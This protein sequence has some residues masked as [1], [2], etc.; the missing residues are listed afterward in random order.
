MQTYSP[1]S[2]ILEFKRASYFHCQSSASV[3]YKKSIP[4]NISQCLGTSTFHHSF[5]SSKTQDKETS[6]MD[7]GNNDR[8][9]LHKAW[10]I[11]SFTTTETADLVSDSIDLVRFAGLNA[12][13]T[14]ENALKCEWT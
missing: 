6:S 1:Y 7:D 11:K 4:C 8:A 10:G 14:K 5:S 3:S 9:V 13:N 12:E 2:I